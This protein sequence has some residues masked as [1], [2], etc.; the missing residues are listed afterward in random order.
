M[1]NLQP[2]NKT[3]DQSTRCIDKLVEDNNAITKINFIAILEGNNKIV[4]QN[5]SELEK[6]SDRGKITLTNQFDKIMNQNNNAFINKVERKME[7]IMK[8]FQS[9][10]I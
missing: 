2:K 4:V 8:E 1:N 3:Q 7:S 5:I 10:I 9:Y 6:W